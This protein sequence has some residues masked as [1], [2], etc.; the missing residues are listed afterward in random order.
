MASSK[1]P[2][3]DE[4]AVVTGDDN[5]YDDDGE[6]LDLEPGESVVGEIRA[7][8]ENCG[9]HNTTVLE[10]SRGLGDNVTMWSNR[11][12]DRVLEKNEIGVGE[13]VG[14]KH[15]TETDTFTPSDSD[16]PVTFDVWEVR[17]GLDGGDA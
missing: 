13:V 6:W 2:A 15:T 17:C 10:L 14:I 3:F 5:N 4:M 7:I 11:Q 12:I 8:N 16:E 1:N 9:Q